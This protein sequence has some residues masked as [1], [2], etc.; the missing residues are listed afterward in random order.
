MQKNAPKPAPE[1]AQDQDE[2]AAAREWAD[3]EA[4]KIGYIWA[5][6][7]PDGRDWL[8]PGHG[9]PCPLSPVCGPR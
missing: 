5:R 8:P 9:G 6:R 3:Q 1:A 4:A 2:E 7:Y